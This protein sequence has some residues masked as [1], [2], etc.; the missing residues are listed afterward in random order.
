M[1]HRRGFTLTEQLLAMGAGSVLMMLAVSLVHRSMLIASEA[2]SRCDNFHHCDRL[3]DQFREDVHWATDVKLDGPSE[4]QITRD[5]TSVTYR[6]DGSDGQRRLGESESFESFKL[7]PETVV[8]FRI[9]A[10]PQ[11]VTLQ[12]SRG[13]RTTMRV[14]AV[15]GRLKRIVEPVGNAEQTSATDESSSRSPD[16]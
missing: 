9:E 3:A 2:R 4:L 10:G 7:D 5:D 11:R 12:A 14:V 6:F 15:T 13:D 1:R 8:D 16:Q